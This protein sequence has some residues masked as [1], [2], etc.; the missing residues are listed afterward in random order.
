MVTPRSPAQTDKA[1]PKEPREGPRAHGIS[2]P[3]APHRIIY[4]L[5]LD[6]I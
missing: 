6:G 5:L 3:H 2:S 1:T 4:G